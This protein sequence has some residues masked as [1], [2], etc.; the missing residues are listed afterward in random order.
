MEHPDQDKKGEG[1]IARTG[2]RSNGVSLRS[3]FEPMAA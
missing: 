2:E 3:F 1:M